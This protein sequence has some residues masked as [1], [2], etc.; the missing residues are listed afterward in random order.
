M[1]KNAIV[2]VY[3][4][5][6]PSMD[7]IRT[8]GKAVM[9]HTNSVPESVEVYTLNEKEITAALVAKAIGTERREIDEEYTTE[10][11]A[12]IYI[13]TLFPDKP[14]TFSAKISARY[15]LAI[16][17]NNEEKLVTAVRAIAQG[18]WDNIRIAVRNKYDFG[19]AEYSIVKSIYD[20]CAGHFA[21]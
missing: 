3:K 19:S 12:V 8:V 2:V 20:S 7:C 4:G 14:L 17:Q 21:G 9:R 1:D 15:A 11:A 6:S 5:D 16:L 13:R 10:E 18:S